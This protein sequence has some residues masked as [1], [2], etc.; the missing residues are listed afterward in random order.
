MQSKLIIIAAIVLAFAG[1][2]SAACPP[3]V[4]GNTAE[5][6]AANAQRLVCLQQELAATTRQQSYQLDLN[7][8]KRSVDDLQLQQRLNT[9]P[10]YTPPAT[11]R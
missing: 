2:A 4:T 7:Q 6:I 3:S 1:P 8:L 11:L 5:A 10:V 9:I